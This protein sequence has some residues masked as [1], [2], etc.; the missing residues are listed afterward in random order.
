MIGVFTLPLT[1]AAFV[2]DDQAIRLLLKHGAEINLPE[3]SSSDESTALTTALYAGQHNTAQLLLQNGADVN[4]E[5]RGIY[6][7]AT[8]GEYDTLKLLIEAGAS[9]EVMQQ[10]LAGAASAANYDKLVLLLQHGARADGPLEMT[11]FQEETSGHDLAS[12]SPKQRKDDISETP[13]VAAVGAQWAD[14]PDSDPL[15]CLLALLDAGAKPNRVSCREYFLADDFIFERGC[16][17]V[18]PGPKTTALLTAAYFGH[19]SMIR[20]LVQ[21][22]ED[23]NF[24]VADYENALATSL[25]AEGY[26]RKDSDVGR[27]LENTHSSSLQRRSTLQLLIELGADLSLCSQDDQ[28]RAAQ[29]LNMSHDDLDNMTALEWLALQPK[30]SNGLEYD[31][32]VK[33][34]DRVE[35][36]RSLI[37]R[38]ADPGLCC[39]RD[40]RKISELLQWSDLE[41]TTADGKRDAYQTSM[42]MAERGP[43]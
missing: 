24:C 29:L 37:D 13:L 32:P 21:R 14:K 42:A 3:S 38:G 28:K 9:I 2:G 36:L 5:A 15:K 20:V 34:R 4:L 22:G 19:M 8:H 30:L 6:E 1:I 40:Q 12:L 41:I 10:A 35:R 31:H 7:A 11:I 23:V 33:F 18:P 39:S 26:E 16:W 25:R 27:E 17:S 43:L